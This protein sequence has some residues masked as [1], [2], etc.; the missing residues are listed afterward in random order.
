VRANYPETV[1]LVLTAH[2][3]DCYLAKAIEAGIVGYLLKDETPSSIVQ[4]IRCAARGEIFLTQKQLARANHWCKEVKERW[5]SLPLVDSTRQ[6][7]SK[8]PKKDGHFSDGKPP[9]I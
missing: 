2:D 1:T 5:N 8:R 4:A 9:R 7:Y 3:R 6:T